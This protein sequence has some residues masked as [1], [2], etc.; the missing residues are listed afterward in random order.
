MSLSIRAKA[1]S[2]DISPAIACPVRVL[3]SLQD[4]MERLYGDPLQLWRP[5]VAGPLDGFGIQ[6]G[7]HVAEAA[8]RPLAAAIR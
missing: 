7:H 3:W 8:P 6:S 4:D 5:W 1:S 2:S